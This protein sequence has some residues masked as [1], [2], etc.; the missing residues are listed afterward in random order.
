MAAPVRQRTDRLFHR[1][2]AH[3]G[4]AT[5]SQPWAPADT[6]PAGWQAGCGPKRR[7]TG[8]LAREEKLEEP[9][10]VPRHGAPPSHPWLVLTELAPTAPLALPLP[11]PVLGIHG[12]ALGTQMLCDHLLAKMKTTRYPVEP[13]GQEI[14]RD[15]ARASLT[16]P[17]L[18]GRFVLDGMGIDLVHPHLGASSLPP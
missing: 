16:P 6:A 18:V 10:T 8:P 17:L 14:G 15:Q 7:K 2:G 1:G 9:S 12:P 4:Q 3:A 13:V 11:L 5:A